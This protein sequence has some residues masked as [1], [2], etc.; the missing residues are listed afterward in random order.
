[1]QSQPSPAASP[2]HPPPRLGLTNP[3]PFP[4]PGEGQGSSHHGSPRSPLGDPEGPCR[5][6]HST[7]GCRGWHST[8]SAQSWEGT[9]VLPAGTRGGGEQRNP[10]RGGA[11]T[12]QDWGG[13][14]WA[15]TGSAS[16]EPPGGTDTQGSSGQ[17]QPEELGLAFGNDPSPSSPK[18]T[19]CTPWSS[20]PPSAAGPTPS[21]RRAA[22]CGDACTCRG[23]PRGQGAL[24]PAPLQHRDCPAAP[25]PGAGTRGTVPLV[26]GWPRSW[27]DPGKA[28]SIQGRVA[29]GTA[30]GGQPGGHSPNHLLGRRSEA[31]AELA[32]LLLGKR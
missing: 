31:A 3:P 8:S 17:Q 28:S 12:A 21:P 16:S 24:P 26:P 1:M 7:T 5:A 6:G 10:A 11:L 14:G 22:G 30:R 23:T 25:T 32:E 9:G 18:D 19:G 13:W 29:G 2:H 20:R 27:A 4:G 15:G